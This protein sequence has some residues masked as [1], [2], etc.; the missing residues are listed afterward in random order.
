M[1]KSPSS[2]RASHRAASTWNRFSGVASWNCTV[3]AG[4]GFFCGAAS[5]SATEPRTSPRMAWNSSRR[6][7]W[8]F[9]L[10]AA[11]SSACGAEPSG[12]TTSTSKKGTSE[13]DS[14]SESSFATT[15]EAAAAAPATTPLTSLPSFLT[16]STTTSPSSSPSF[17]FVG[18]SGGDPLAAA[19]LSRARCASATARS[20]ASRR[21]LLRTARSPSPPLAV[22]ESEF[23]DVDVSDTSELSDP[24]LAVAAATRGV[25]C[26]E[27]AGALFSSGLRGSASRAGRLSRSGVATCFRAASECVFSSLAKASRVA[28]PTAFSLSFFSSRLRLRPSRVGLLKSL[29][30]ANAFSISFRSVSGALLAFAASFTTSVSTASTTSRSTTHEPCAATARW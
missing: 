11:A 21:R 20:T 24:E 27:S 6:G 13:S 1:P 16:S 28:R 10:D 19:F 30:P 18:V 15:S 5:E 3:D 25:S 29:P 26:A 2:L 17:F 7:G 9:R 12:A 4:G 14:E 8:L 23:S 22:S